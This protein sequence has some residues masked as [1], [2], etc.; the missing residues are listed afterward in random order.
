ML[1]SSPNT[2]PCGTA[3]IKRLASSSTSWCGDSR[4]EVGRKD[5]TPLRDRVSAERRTLPWLKVEKLY[6]FARPDGQNADGRCGRPIDAR[7]A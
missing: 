5:F 1:S 4:A 6:V 3:T 2:R 7:P